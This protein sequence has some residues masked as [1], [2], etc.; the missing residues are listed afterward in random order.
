MM[1]PKQFLRDDPMIRC[2]G[3]R[4]QGK[5]AKLTREHLMQKPDSNKVADMRLY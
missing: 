2:Q 4:E 5:L 3:K 1:N